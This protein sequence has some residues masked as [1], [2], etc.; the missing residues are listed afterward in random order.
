MSSRLSVSNPSLPWTI[1]AHRKTTIL[2]FVII[3]CLFVLPVV[4]A[5][6]IYSHTSKVADVTVAVYATSHKGGDFLQENAVFEIVRE[7]FSLRSPETPYYKA[8]VRVVYGDDYTPKHLV[9]YLLHRDKYLAEIAKIS[10]GKFYNVTSVEIGYE[11]EDS[12]LS[13]GVTYKGSYSCPDETIGAV[14]GTYPT[15]IPT[16][17]TGIKKAVQLAEDAGYKVKLLLGNQASV[18]AYRSWLQCENVKVFGNIGHGLP[19]GIQL[20][21][22]ELSY[23]WFKSLAGDVLDCKTLYFCSCQVHKSPLE[24]AIIGAGASRF[25][26]G[27]VNLLIG[28]A[29]E[30]FKC[31]WGTALEQKTPV[32]PIIAQCERD[33]YPYT[34]HHGISGDGLLPW[35]CGRIGAPCS[36][37]SSCIE[38]VCEDEVCCE[39]TCDEV[40][41][42]CNVE[43]FR[44]TCTP[45]PNGTSCSDGDVCNGKEVCLLDEC[46]SGDSLNCDDEDPCTQNVC[47]PVAGCSWPAVENGTLCLDD[48][49]CDGEEACLDGVC[50]EAAE[51]TDCNDHNPCTQDSCDILTGCIH[52]GLPDDTSCGD[53]NQCGPATC[54]GGFCVP[55]DPAE[56]ED[57][58][59]CTRDWCDPDTGQCVSEPKGEGEE[60]GKYM[61]CIESKCVPDM[62]RMVVEGKWAGCGLYTDSATTGPVMGWVLVILI[63]LYVR[64]RQ[65]SSN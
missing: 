38:G 18:S 42:F 48:D 20:A 23:S 61:L 25:I 40:C 39:T 12:D 52:E 10:L 15:E 31:F 57:S 36:G 19:S 65:V 11:Q 51:P 43:G 5:G 24:P 59:L 62:D 22:G 27:D 46:V 3:S 45:A 33:F 6:E 1:V 37:Q 55:E 49:L 28:P 2:L 34:G 44:G 32:E 13:Q 8:D 50:Q 21:G 64:K 4:T 41:V 7:Q 56:C 26:G 60:C 16:A 54:M 17:V 30:V 14:F 53:T 9:V 63:I 47:D 29:E 58:D 35:E